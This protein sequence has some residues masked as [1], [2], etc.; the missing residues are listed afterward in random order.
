DKATVVVSAAGYEAQSYVVST[1]QNDIARYDFSLKKIIL[2]KI[3]IVDFA[4][5]RNSLKAFEVTTFSGTIKNSGE[6]TDEVVVQAQI[7]APDGQLVQEIAISDE[8]A[9][10]SHVFAIAPGEI[11]NI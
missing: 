8:L 9:G 11:K 2:S 5:S 3:D 7:W 10:D 4:S 1:P 6:E